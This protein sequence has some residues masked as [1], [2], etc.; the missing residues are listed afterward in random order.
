MINN[1]NNSLMNL[2]VTE[3]E[4]SIIKNLLS[5]DLERTERSLE[6]CNKEIT[7]ADG[8][9]KKYKSGYYD[10]AHGERIVLNQIKL[11]GGKLETSRYRRDVLMEEVYQLEKLLHEVSITQK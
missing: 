1:K 2:Q 4:L 9:L 7:E 8:L 3:Y 5:K 6:F 10:E 11:W